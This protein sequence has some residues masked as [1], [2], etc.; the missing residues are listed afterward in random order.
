MTAMPDTTAATTQVYAVYIRATPEQI[1]TAITDPEWNRRYGYGAPAEYDLRPGGAYRG[2]P[3]EAMAGPG[4]PDVIIEGEVL[5]SD[6]P[7]RL[8][9]T[10][11]ALW[12]P[13]LQAE[14]PTRLTWEIEPAFGDTTRLTITHELRGAPTHAL[15]VAGR[16]PE[17][18]G[19]WAWIVSD[20]KTLLETGGGLSGS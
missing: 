11:H 16:I 2:L 17:T 19:G 18:G 8:V 5:E 1:W 6:P 15:Q 3:S 13:E 14:P 7:R 12:S 10:W 4:T 9:Q 20:L